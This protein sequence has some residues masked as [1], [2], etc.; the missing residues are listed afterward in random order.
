M[1]VIKTPH[2]GHDQRRQ[3]ICHADLFAPDQIQPHAEHQHGADQR[4]VAERRIGEDRLQEPCQQRHAAL[5]DADRDGGEDAALAHRGRHDHDD[6]KIE[7]G[8]GEQRRV[9]AEDAVL[10]GA[11][12][13]HRADADRER[14]GDEG[15]DEAA[16]R[17]A[18]RLD[19]EPGAEA[20][21][22]VLEIKQLA[23]NRADGQREDH[24]HGPLHRQ[25]P[26]FR[27]Q[28]LRKRARDAHEQHAHAHGAHQRFLQPL[29]DA[30]PAE[31]ARESSNND[32]RDIDDRPQSVHPRF[33]PSISC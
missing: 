29:R 2:D 27:A 5:Q 3:Q 12:D 18:F 6:H 22:P 26:A 10:D 33:S 11:D 31:Q 15:A 32:R 16:V 19:L 24:H 17:L 20:L 13:G 25:R 28:H 14:R 30:P 1:I 7:H 8:L 9:V 21:H 23:Q 4:Q